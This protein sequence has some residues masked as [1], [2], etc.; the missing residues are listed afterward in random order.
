MATNPI[1]AYVSQGLTDYAFGIF[2]DYAGIMADADFLAPRVVTGAS[3]GD[4]AK[5]DSK[6]AF[7]AYDA[8]RSV[9]GQRQRI[10]FAGE[11]GSFNC[12]AKALE[13]GLDDQEINRS[14]GD[15]SLIEQA[16][17]R[18]L[19]STFALSRFNR[20]Y[21]AATTSGNFTAATATNAGAWSNPNVD[22]VADIDAAIAQVYA[23]SGMLPNRMTLDFGSWQKF[24][25]H[26][27]VIARQPGAAI[28]G[29]SLQQASSMFSAPLEVRLAAGAKGT[30]GFGSSTTTKA[31][32]QSAV[33]L[34]FRAEPSATAY[35][36]SALKT[37]S[38]SANGFD[39]VK[40]YRE[41]SSSSDIFYIEVE[42]D[43]V[44]VSAL[45]IVKISVT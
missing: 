28:V 40:Q 24:R 23:A 36:P 11:T 41:E 25:N 16:K 38:P 1:G 22:P 42:E 9:G 5:F 18:T 39:A 15:R 12:R 3:V 21:T 19:L 31:A 6:Q 32:V 10:K 13:V 14:K 30:T 2:Q 34:V 45:L 35:D 37:F 20:V 29:V 26:P 7:L 17:V 33:C 43:I 4:F 8:N 44:S 27:K